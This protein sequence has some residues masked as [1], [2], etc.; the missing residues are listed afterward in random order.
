MEAKYRCWGD[1][2][3]VTAKVYLEQHGAKAGN[4]SEVDLYCDGQVRRHEVTV[5]TWEGRLRD[6]HA[7][8]YWKYTDDGRDLA[9]ANRPVWVH[10]VHDHDRHDKDRHHGKHHH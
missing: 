5:Y 8:L 9:S 2:R 1:G 6:G 4:R 7:H 10:G 3:D